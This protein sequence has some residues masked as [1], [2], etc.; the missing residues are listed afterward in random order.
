MSWESLAQLV[1]AATEA[2]S[3]IGQ[4]ALCQEAREQEVSEAALLKRMD[5]HL[6]VMQEAAHRG[7]EA[8]VYSQ[9]GFTGGQAPLLARYAETHTTLSG[10]ETVQVA[11]MA[12]AVMEVNASMGRIVAAP[13]AG[14]SGIMPAVVT[15]VA[16]RLQLPREKVVLSLFCAGAVGMVIANIAGISGAEAG[17]QAEVGAAAAMGAAAAVELADGTPHQVAQAAAIM[18]KNVLGLVCDPV[19]GLVEVPCIKRNG[20]Y[21]AMAILAADMA[22]AGVE[23]VIPPDEVI[24]ALA[25][26]GKAMPMSLRETAQGGLAATPTGQRLMAELQASSH[27]GSSL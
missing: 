27:W 1:T 2:G 13:T 26:V 4:V 6:T 21:A 25:E 5:E 12:T 9:R 10:K 16:E 14:S 11:A 20:M 3:S 8:P 19:A 23:S 17:C 22:L 24:A 7:L 18:L 15:L